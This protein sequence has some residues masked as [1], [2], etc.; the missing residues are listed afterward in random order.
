MKQNLFFLL[1]VIFIGLFLFLSCQKEISCP[2]CI[3]V[4]KPPIAKAGN[5][6]AIV[7]PTDSVQLDGS[8]SNDPDGTI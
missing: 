8:G 1:T 6:K 3:T 7:L 2:E 4:N 5:D